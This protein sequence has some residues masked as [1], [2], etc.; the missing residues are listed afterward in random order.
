LARLTRFR[1]PNTLPD[2]RRPQVVADTA[3]GKA[4]ETLGRQ[5]G[6]SSRDVVRLGRLLNKRQEGLD[7]LTREKAKLE[8]DKKLKETEAFER[9][10]HQPA[11]AGFTE[12]MLA[13]YVREGQ[14]VIEAQPERLRPQLAAELE[15]QRALYAKRF[16]AAEYGASQNFVRSGIDE[17]IESQK[18][19]VAEDPASV[20][21]ALERVVR[22]LGSAALPDS[23]TRALQSSSRDTL[24]E[25]WFKSFAP[26]T[27]L[28]LIEQAEKTDEDLDATQPTTAASSKGG[29]R[30]RELTP[31]ARGR[32][33]A[34]AQA[35]LAI[36]EI[37]ESEELAGLIASEG[38]GFDPQMIRQSSRLD[39]AH[40]RQLLTL[41][42]GQ[43]QRD[44][45]ELAA[46]DW[47]RNPGAADQRSPTDRERADRAF[48]RLKQGGGEPDQLARQM[49]RRKGVLPETYA[50]GL[51]SE[52]HSTN[53]AVLQSAHETLSALAQIEAEPIRSGLNG[54]VLE[55]GLRK[56]RVLVE[57]RGL[58]APQAARKLALANDPDRRK[59]LESELTADPV[60]MG[61]AQL[62]AQHLLARLAG[63]ELAGGASV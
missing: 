40:K 59:G 10:A 3:V 26:E 63:H 20:D 36:A 58:D 9:Q 55:D 43:L 56:W 14:A 48:Q 18:A 31:A 35:D 15:Q 42:D 29:S 51:A 34:E 46:I 30:V 33:K 52:L 2:V 24:I 11:G 57:L 39:P 61:G 5:I 4:T 54:R 38:S 47:L 6:Q 44:Q 1:G 49:L 23:V 12:T 60:R 50:A 28:E 25:T 27:R 8:L 45:T 62:D 41:L 16:A 32:L 7:A 21:L 22:V 13:H 17:I 19:L 37:R 53:A